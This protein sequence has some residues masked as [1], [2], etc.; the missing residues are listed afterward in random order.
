LLVI[1]AALAGWLFYRSVSGVIEGVRIQRQWMPL[2]VPYTAHVIGHADRGG[3]KAKVTAL[4][5][6]IRF[7]DGT[8][9][10][11]TSSRSGSL[12]LLGIGDEV[13]LLT[14]TTQMFGRSWDVYEIDSSFELW[15]KDL[16]WAIGVLC[17]VIGVPLWTI[18]PLKWRR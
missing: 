4:T 15:V 18:R 3:V 9:K 8:K 13:R 17:F 12:H 1:A 2:R 7:G 6:E 14:R 5:V 11:F 16:L 10:Q